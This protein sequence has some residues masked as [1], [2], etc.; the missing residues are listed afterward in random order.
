MMM[1]ENEKLVEM[2]L[3]VK[4]EAEVA[5]RAESMGLSVSEYV[6]CVLRQHVDADL[7]LA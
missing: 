4:M 6:A 7:M 5:V 3:S 2:T 1:D